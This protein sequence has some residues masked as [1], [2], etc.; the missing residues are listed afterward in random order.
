MDITALH[1][2]SIVPADPDIGNADIDLRWYAVHSQPHREAR[3]QAQ[4]DNQG[5]RTY[6]PKRLKTV[7]HARKLKTVVAPFFPRYLFIALDLGRHQWRCVNST[8]GVSCL[9]MAGERPH[10][11]PPGVVEAMIAST[12]HNGLL[13]FE[14]KLTVGASVRLLAGPF[15]EQLGTLERLDDSGRV[16]VLLDIMGGAIPVQIARELVAAA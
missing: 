6:L 8:F 4:L 2:A 10:P 9:V 11:V 12:E 7:R 3:A 16:R 13:S 15:A 5:F 1:D 14:Q